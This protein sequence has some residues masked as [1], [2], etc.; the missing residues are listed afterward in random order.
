MYSLFYHDADVI[1]TQAKQSVGYLEELGAKP[2]RFEVIPGGCHLPD[3][4]EALPEMF[5]VGYFGSL[6]P[7]KGVGYLIDAWLKLGYK[8]AE[9]VFGGDGSGE[10]YDQLKPYA[11][12]ANF[13][14]LGHLDNVSDFYNYI[15]ILVQPSVTE[16]FALTVLEAMAH[17]R[18]CVVSKGAGVW[19]LLTDGIDGLLC[20]PRDVEGM[21]QRIDWLKCHPEKIAGMGEAAR[22]TA[23]QYTWDRAQA[24]YE[25]VISEGA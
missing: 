15:S 12:Q 14:V 7:D 23:E 8:D 19:E 24:E 17:G 9:L 20:F 4:Y 11:D 22:R 25:R 6:G 5:R 13:R 21:A 1:I 3:S 10:L 16:G 2:T 18:P